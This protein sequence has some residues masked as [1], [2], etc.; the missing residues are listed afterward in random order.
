[1]SLMSHRIGMVEWV[2][3]EVEVVLHRGGASSHVVG[4]HVV[5][6]ANVDVVL[7]DV[8]DV[9][10]GCCVVHWDGVQILESIWFHC[11][12]TF[13]DWF[14]SVLPYWHMYVDEKREEDFG[15]MQFQ[16]L[17]KWLRVKLVTF[18]QFVVDVVAVV[19]CIVNVVIVV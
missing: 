14:C 15:W 2:L 3:S 16:I 5:V 10:L 17:G 19:A 8:H 4:F 7:D 6:D 18:G 11:D 12:V 1:M 9:A 13:V